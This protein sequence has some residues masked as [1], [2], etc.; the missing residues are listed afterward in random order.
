[1]PSYKLLNGVAHNIMDHA[2]SG[3][4]FLHPHLGKVCRLAN[5]KKISLDLTKKNPLPPGLPYDQPLTLSTITLHGKFLEILEKGGFTLSYITS[6]NLIFEF[7]ED[8]LEDNDRFSCVSELIT[9]KGK[10]YRHEMN[11][12]TYYDP[13]L[14][15]KS[16]NYKN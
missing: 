10:L 2:V 16:E 15:F 14:K 5:I 12:D 4:S 1:M 7:P 8:S 3:L 11:T 13:Y 9:A 6:A